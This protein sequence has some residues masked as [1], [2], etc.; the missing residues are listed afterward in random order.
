PSA[1]GHTMRAWIFLSTVTALALSLSGSSRAAQSLPSEKFL[2]L[3]LSLEAAQAVM[4]ACDKPPNR[5]IALVVVDR[6]GQTILWMIGDGGRVTSAELARGKA[7]T[8][9]LTGMS[10]AAYSKSL[11]TRIDGGKSSPPDPNLTGGEG[12]LPVIAA[13]ETIGGIGVSGSAPETG[14]DEACSQRGIDKIKD[15]LR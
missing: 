11:E 13:G 2:P 15:R 7:Y 4:A 3:A 12:G 10:S 14:G 1:I 5:P 8:S 6:K 9:A